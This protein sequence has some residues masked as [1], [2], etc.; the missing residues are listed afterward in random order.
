MCFS[1]NATVQYFRG[2]CKQRP[3]IFASTMG[4]CWRQEGNW[5]TPNLQTFRGL[6]S[7][8]R[9]NPCKV[10]TVARRVQINL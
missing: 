7:T 6:S 10:I 2:N 9:T 4:N 3:N 1:E 5:L 8:F